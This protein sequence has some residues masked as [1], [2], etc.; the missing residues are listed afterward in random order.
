LVPGATETGTRGGLPSWAEPEL[1]T[2]THDR[3]S[4]PAWIFERKLDGERCL[5]FA[6]SSGVRLMSRT[7]REITT[8][9][10]EVAGALA[11][12]HSGDLLVDG[13]IVA[14]DGTRTRFE[15]LQLRLGVADPSDA[16][17]RE[18]PVDYYVFDVLYAEDRDVRSLPLLQ[19][20]Q[21]LTRCLGFRG[22]LRF[23][24]H[25]ERDGEALFAQACRDGWEGLVAKRADAPYRSGRSRD[26]LK[27][28]CLN[29]QEFVIGGYTDP[30]RSRVGFG[31]LL[32][33]YHDADGDLVYAGKVGTGF[34]TST[35]RGLGERLA[36]LERDFPAFG[37][38]RLP[39][40]RGVHWVEPRL[41][42]QIGF[43]EWTDDGQLR[44]PRFQGLRDD[45]DPAAV[46]REV[47]A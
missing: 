9:F 2:L 44:Q 19:R 21:I 38:G 34:D 14:F 35:L 15:R 47:P 45:K 10:P 11:A 24:E 22:P 1:A 25:R 20:K 7:Q 28:K 5:A 4:D 32:L 6:D 18:V 3:F 26:W 30:Q 43:A 16:L 39:G 41:V 13:E 33:G 36:G 27:F 31:A 29:G 12:R 46:V 23:T 8:T 17:L 42:A 40:A 37:K